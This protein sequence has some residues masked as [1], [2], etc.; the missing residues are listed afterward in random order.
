MA[1]MAAH[2]DPQVP[3]NH[4]ATSMGLTSR[5]VSATRDR[6]ASRGIIEAARHGYL[7]FT[8]PGFTEYVRDVAGLEPASTTPNARTLQTVPTTDPPTGRQ[9]APPASPP[10]HVP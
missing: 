4:I 2:P 5:A 9:L 8:L 1:A 3:R 7:R 6:L 10:F